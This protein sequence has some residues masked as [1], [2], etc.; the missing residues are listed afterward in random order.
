MSICCAMDGADFSLSVVGGGIDRAW[1]QHGV[2]LLVV[3]VLFGGGPLADSNNQ[4]R[5]RQWCMIRLP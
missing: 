3:V 1:P 5:P 2:V 4:E